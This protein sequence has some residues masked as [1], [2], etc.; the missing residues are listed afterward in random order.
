MARGSI[1]Q[2]PSAA[3]KAPEPSPSAAS[4][5]QQKHSDLAGLLA[6]LDRQEITEEQ[7]L[8]GLGDLQEIQADHAGSNTVEAP[9]STEAQE[10][11]E[12]EQLETVDGD[13]VDCT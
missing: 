3:E 6:S 9:G 5:K 4:D 12:T 7:F 1:A 11:L 2:H 10:N 13:A 8:E